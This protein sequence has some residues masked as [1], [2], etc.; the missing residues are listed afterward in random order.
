[1]SQI[2]RKAVAQDQSAIWTL[3]QQAIKRR[4]EEGSRQWQDGYPNE[5]VIKT[6]ILNAQG[7]V[8]IVDEMVAAYAA[9]LLNDEPAYDDLV[10]Q[11]LSQ[12]TFVVLHRLAVSDDHLGKGFAE[13]MLK[14]TEK[15][16]LE[17]DIVSVK[18]DTN[19]DNG[20]MLYLFN[21]LGYSYCGEVTFRGGK[22]KAFEKLLK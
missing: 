18:A 5:E 11:W 22:R 13:Q 15:I 3:V 1:M 17:N 16:A 20:P 21:K 19:F 12:G 6:D 4:K 7:Y 14:H 10:G 9:I 2:I 8:L